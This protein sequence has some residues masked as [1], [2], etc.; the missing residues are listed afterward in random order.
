MDGNTLTALIVG[1]SALVGSVGSVA[2]QLRR[3]DPEN[4]KALKQRAEN[5]EKRAEAAER[6]K[7]RLRTFVLYLRARIYADQSLSVSSGWKSAEQVSAERHGDDVAARH[8][9]DDEEDTS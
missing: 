9:D 5:A 6:A 2:V 1:L 3:S 4:V 7:D 8:A